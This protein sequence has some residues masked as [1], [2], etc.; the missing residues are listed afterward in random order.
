[1]EC[2]VW[3]IG[4]HVSLLGGGCFFIDSDSG[5]VAI[6]EIS[7]LSTSPGLNSG[8]RRSST[9]WRNNGLTIW[10]HPLSTAAHRLGPSIINGGMKP[11]AHC[12]P[13]HKRLFTTDQKGHVAAS[14]GIHEEVLGVDG[15]N[16]AASQTRLSMSHR[17][18]QDASWP[19]AGE[20]RHLPKPS[21]AKTKQGRGM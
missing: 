18:L 20:S 3:G 16:E 2:R 9:Q 19:V 17:A 12:A 8:P 4:W 15:H 21:A 10:G 1:M 14:T 13:R 11:L 7:H 5:N 6:E